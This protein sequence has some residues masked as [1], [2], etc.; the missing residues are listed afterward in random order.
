ME[1]EEGK[2]V[3]LFLDRKEYEIKKLYSES[4]IIKNKNKTTKIDHWFADLHSI[5]GLTLRRV[6]I[7]LLQIL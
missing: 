5:D 2:K 3:I 7:D 4:I 6:S 1:I